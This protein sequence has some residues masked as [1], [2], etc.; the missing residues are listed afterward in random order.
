MQTPGTSSKD[1]SANDDVFNSLVQRDMSGV[2]KQ[3]GGLGTAAG[4]KM[5]AMYNAEESAKKR[6]QYRMELGT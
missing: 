6:A 4:R 5:Y 1:P 3:F 2:Y